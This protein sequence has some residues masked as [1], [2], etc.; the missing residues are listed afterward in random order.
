M[1]KIII[2]LCIC[3]FIGNCFYSKAEGR[4]IVEGILNDAIFIK[5]VGSNIAKS[6]RAIAYVKPEDG[7]K[8][9]EFVFSKDKLENRMILICNKNFTF[10]E[11]HEGQEVRV[12]VDGTS[13]DVQG[14]N[15]KVNRYLYNW[16]QE[17]IMKPQNALKVRLLREH[18]DYNRAGAF[19]QNGIG[20]EENLKYLEQLDKLNRKLLNQS[21]IEDREFLARQNIAVEYQVMYMDFLNYMYMKGLG[22]KMPESY[23]KKLRSYRLNTP[24]MKE[25]ENYYSILYNYLVLQEDFEGLEYG[26]FNEVSNKAKFIE[27]EILRDDFILY[28][29]NRSLIYK[30]FFMLDRIAEECVPLLTLE[31]SKEDMAVLLDKIKKMAQENNKYGEKA[32]PFKYK[33]EKGEW[34]SLTDYA[35]M[36]VFLDIWATWCAPCKGQLPFMKEMENELHGLNIAFVSISVD[37]PRDRNKWLAFIKDHEMAGTT[38]VSNNGFKDPMVAFYK[39]KGIPR[40][41]LIDPDGNIVSAYCKRPQSKEFRNYVKQLVET[42]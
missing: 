39:I 29:L 30:N 14:D 22:Q 31:K 27:N 32:Y 8:L 18:L 3:F 40:F 25:Y 10:I 4:I 20:T 6:A 37:I 1:K 11:L 21:G 13:M 17:T 35:G 23:E 7:K 15:N 33:N 19:R 42:N 9:Y 36:Y 2:Y 5:S 38:L 12:V 41:I 24:K 16:A 26:I 28:T 34:I